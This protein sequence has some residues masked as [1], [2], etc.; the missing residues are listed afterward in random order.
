V[1]TTQGSTLESLL[2]VQAFLNDNVEKL[3]GIAK[4]GA[5]QKLDD[6]IAELSA[7]ATD[8]T[9]HN[10][11]AQGATKNTRALRVV[12]LRDHM[13]PI[14]RIARADLPPTP[15][16]EP[17]KMPKGKPTTAKLAKL[18]DGM[19][20]AAA[21]FADAF[22]SAGLPPDF[23]AQLN[24]ATDALLASVVENSQNRGK[25]HRATTGLKQRLSAARKIVHVLDAFVKTALKDDPALL[26][27]WNLV[28]RVRR[29]GSRAATPETPPPATPTATPSAQ[30]TASATS[31]AVIPAASPP[32]HVDAPT[33]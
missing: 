26:A 7:H 32:P 1:Q 14:A 29:T 25:R 23:V 18:A 17:L 8:Q 3:A 2:F 5:R 31:A 10:L 19:A 15:A 24:G 28:K 16:I 27:N 20:Q 13:A 6:A 4:T 11:A 12:L 30:P 22:V 21:P 33:A 9:G